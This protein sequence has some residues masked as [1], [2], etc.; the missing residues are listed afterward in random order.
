MSE[1]VDDVK[2]NLIE[3]VSNLGITLTSD[4]TQVNHTKKGTFSIASNGY[5]NIK[6]GDDVDEGTGGDITITAG[7][8]ANNGKGGDINIIAGTG[9][10]GDN[11]QG[12]DVNIEGGRA[13]GTNDNGGSVSI[14]AGQ[15]GSTTK[16]GNVSINGGDSTGTENGGDILLYGGGAGG[17][18]G[19]FG[20]IQ[21]QSLFRVAVYE[22]DTARNAY[23]SPLTGDICF[24]IT[25][26][27]P[28]GN[29]KLQVYTGS[30]W[31]ICN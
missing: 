19:N 28:A 31:A 10:L 20:R 11:V 29:N 9:N 23:N 7:L 6:S 22:N 27:N 21:C 4:N 24:V 5:L 2:V 13:R 1:I 26:T 14:S 25:G 18:G 12:G 16:G 15:G 8:G 30:G 17:G 3:A